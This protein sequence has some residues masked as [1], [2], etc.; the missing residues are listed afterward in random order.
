ME[1]ERTERAEHEGQ[2]EQQ[3]VGAWGTENQMLHQ[4]REKIEN[5]KCMADV[6]FRLVSL[7]PISSAL[8][9]G[10]MVVAYR[11]RY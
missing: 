8:A 1:A 9:F 5:F 4:D 7:E 6:P 10:G 3:E 11:R 2:E